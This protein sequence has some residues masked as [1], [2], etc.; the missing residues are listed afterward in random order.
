MP[1]L[2]SFASTRSPCSGFL[3]ASLA[4]LFQIF[5]VDSSSSILH[6]RLTCP[7]VQSLAFFCD[8]AQTP[9][10]LLIHSL[11]FDHHLSPQW[12][13]S[14]HLKPRPLSWALG[15]NTILYDDH[16]LFDH[17]SPPGRFWFTPDSFTHQLCNVGQDTHPLWTAVSQ[18]KIRKSMWKLV[19]VSR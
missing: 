12:L 7:R 17:Q 16:S 18:C 13:S 14:L 6:E 10:L 3:P 19:Q 9:E 4:D 8:A 2:S 15:L 5:F 11:A 1:L